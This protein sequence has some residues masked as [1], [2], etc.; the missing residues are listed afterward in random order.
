[1][2]SVDVTARPAIVH[3]CLR[4]WVCAGTASPIPGCV[5]VCRHWCSMTR[6]GRRRRWPGQQ[7]NCSSSCAL[8]LSATG[9]LGLDVPVLTDLWN[10]VF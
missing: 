7:P 4:C 6:T 5:C 8:S 9:C 3:I 10:S 2:L 1:M